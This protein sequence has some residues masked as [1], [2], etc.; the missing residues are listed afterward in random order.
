MKIQEVLEL[1]LEVEMTDSFQKSMVFGGGG[2]EQVREAAGESRS[3]HLSR[4]FHGGRKAA[5]NV[6]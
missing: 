6:H 5:E 2:W 3:E 1:K 4:R